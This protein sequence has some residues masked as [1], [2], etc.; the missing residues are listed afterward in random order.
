MTNRNTS[1]QAPLPHEKPL[2]LLMDGHAMVHRA[3]HAIERTRAL[4]TRSGEVVSG[5]YGFV[6]AFLKA[7]SEWHPTHVAIAFDLPTPTFRHLEYQAYKAQRPETAPDLQAQFPK[8]RRLVEAFRIPIY[9]AEGYEADDVLG[10]L[11][12][13]AEQAQ[14]ETVILTGDTD[15]LQLVTP[16][17]RV[18]LHY[19]VQE[20]KIYDEAAVRERYGGLGPASQCDVKALTGDTSD[21]IPGV[22]GI[23]P[24]TAIKLITDFGDLEALYQRLDEVKPPRIQ[25]LL[26]Q[27]QAQAV[28]GKRLCTI[29]KDVPVALDLERM[30]FGDYRR[31]DVLAVL[32]EMEF[33]SIVSRI[34]P[35]RGEVA[36]PASPGAPSDPVGAQHAA[37]LPIALPPVQGMLLEVP[38]PGRGATDASAPVS[39]VTVATAE[40][41][42]AMLADLRAA[43]SFAFD[44]ETD[45]L[46]PMLARLVGLSFAARPH[47][48]WYVPVGHII[49]QENREGA[50]N[51]GF[52]AGISGVSPD[53]S[54]PPS[55]IGKG[56][57]EGVRSAP[58]QLPLAD[59]LEAIKPLFADPAVK[60]TAHNANFDLMV[61][62]ENDVDVAGLD[63]DTMIGAH[64]AGRSAIGLKALAFQLLNEEMTPI[65]AL[66][67]SGRKQITFAQAPIDQAARYSA[68]DADMTWRLRLALEPLVASVHGEAILR[69]VELP[70]VPVLVAMQRNGIL[71]DKAR[72]TRMS[73]ALTQQIHTLEEA[74][75]QE[76]GQQFNIN[77]TQQLATVLFEKLL[78]PA[79]LKEMGLPPPR[80]TKTGYSTDSAVLEEVRKAHPVVDLVLEYRQLT[81]LKSTYLE[82]LPTLVNPRTGRIHTSYNQVGSATGRF[83]SSDPNLQNIPIRTDLGREVRRAFLAPDGWSL[84]AADYSQVE[85]RVLAHLS[86]DPGLLAAF[87]RG[88]DIHA[89]TA[90]QVYGVPL[91]QVTPDMRRMAKVMN[92]GIIYGLS[93]HGMS[94][95]TD[96]DMHQSQEFINSYFAKY[97]GILD[98]IE[99]TKRKARS[100][101]YVETLL[102]RRR[103][104]PEIAHSN[105]QVRQA[106]ERMAINMPVQGAAADLIKL[107]MIN[108]HRQ[109][110]TDRLR[111][112]MLLQVHDELIFEV[113]PDELEAMKGLVLDL[114]PSAMQL[115]V[116]LKVEVKLGQNWGEME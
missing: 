71:V 97:P 82:S 1:A 28:Q 40:A 98:Y 58:L 38:A 95:Q 3:Y 33:S 2:L 76:A 13:Q 42:S 75:Y 43:G 60:K 8:V 44:T 16:W 101:G 96:M 45:N 79:K 72:L 25:D 99:Q 24:K 84:L 67:G 73:E 5:V 31:D 57:P 10:T 14:L 48:A 46:D 78:P 83:S 20:R 39:Y 6:N 110:A 9:E 85:L 55:L 103:Y 91:G 19:S 54:P 116:P 18:A 29:V 109:M 4:T 102:G 62:A 77:S 15:T 12:Q 37:P 64:I 115:D 107:A 90:S 80:R 53:N 51:P 63:F 86:Q 52:P 32:R 74:I 21:N 22:P 104:I 59:V 88:E 11:C 70:L 36:S 27:H 41:L 100:L 7:L 114:M 50:G 68:A 106:A 87:H 26:R 89:S 112:R 61:L 23:G 69:D 49:S 35:G 93:A 113:P 105:F 81:K 66:I 47:H 30:R 56:E 34:P 94:Q 92:F 65:S 108:L 17:V 111:S